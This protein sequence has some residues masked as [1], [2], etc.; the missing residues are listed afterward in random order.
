MGK[1]RG[2]N[3]NILTLLLPAFIIGINIISE[4]ASA[5]PVMPP[6]RIL[7]QAFSIELIETNLLINLFLLLLSVIV[8]TRLNKKD[9]GVLPANRRD[10]ILLI[11]CSAIFITISGALIDLTT[12]VSGWWYEGN[13]QFHPHG[14]GSTAGWILALCLIGV[15]VLISCRL[16]LGLRLKYS[17]I[18]ISIF[19]IANPLS[20]F[21]MEDPTTGVYYSAIFPIE[22]ICLL[23]SVLC[24]IYLFRWYSRS[25]QEIES[26]GKTKSLKIM[27]FSDCN[28]FIFFIVATLIALL[29]SLIVD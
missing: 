9:I 16:F 1:K 15:T 21:F 3:L 23:L 29:I 7:A 12:L 28:R 14:I 20:W 8:I 6:G 10:F 24:A 11:L 19:L 5:D 26:G 2:I 25:Q 18:P 27:I 13:Q 17:V 22:I 4:R